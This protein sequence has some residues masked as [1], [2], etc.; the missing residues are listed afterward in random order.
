MVRGVRIGEQLQTVSGQLSRVSNQQKAGATE[1]VSALMQVLASTQEL[2]RTAVQIAESAVQ[3]AAL[4]NDTLGEMKKVE[5]VGNTNQLRTQKMATAVDRT[6]NGVVQ[7][8]QQVEE[9]SLLMGELGK[10]TANIEKVVVLL[11]S[12]ADEVHLLALNASIEAAGAGEY[13]ERFR[14][15]AQEIKQL[16]KRANH[17]TSEA[18]VLIRDVQGSCEAAI[19][20]VDEGLGVVSQVVLS[21]GELGQALDEL[22]LGS[23]QIKQAFNEVRLIAIK[24]NDEAEG[25]K[26]ATA[27]QRISS[28]QV[29]GSVNLVEGVA[30]QSVTS[31]QQVVSSTS[32][33]EN[34]THQLNEVLSQVKLAA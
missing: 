30:Q 34:L 1:Q 17:A 14:V 9:V 18:N 8:G 11:G 24:L 22:E 27:Q 29:I 32:G 5:E 33:L 25:I 26:Q 2:E 10:R 6:L 7:V 13:G 15:V 23:H 20:K 21:S 31:A 19:V 28:T 4:S 12:I 3:V 16:A